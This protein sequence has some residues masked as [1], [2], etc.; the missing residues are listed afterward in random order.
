MGPEAAELVLPA[1]EGAFFKIPTTK[2][3]SIFISADTKLL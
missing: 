1:R 2:L 3:Y